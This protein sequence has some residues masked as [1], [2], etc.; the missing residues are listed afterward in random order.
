MADA[1][2]SSPQSVRSQDT[3]RLEELLTDTEREREKRTALDDPHVNYASRL[4]EILDGADEKELAG[5]GHTSLENGFQ[6]DDEEE[7]EDEDDG[8]FY[9]GEDAPPVVGYAAQLADV[10][11]EDILPDDSL[12]A[13]DANEVQAQL[14][15]DSDQDEVFDYS[16]FRVS[17]IIRG[18]KYPTY[19]CRIG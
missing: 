10:L 7:D 17:V 5:N 11:G 3:F 19:D 12:D 14:Y 18:L 13:R 6:D 1:P 9:T 8:F 2:L 15:A 16:K 4:D